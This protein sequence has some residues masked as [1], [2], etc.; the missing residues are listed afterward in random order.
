MLPA[1]ILKK[2]VCEEKQSNEMGY[3][4]IQKFTVISATNYIRNDSI[5]LYKWWG[6]KREIK[7]L[8]LHEL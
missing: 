2:S 6:K 7:D 1:Y 4:D 5:F 8:P 3:Q